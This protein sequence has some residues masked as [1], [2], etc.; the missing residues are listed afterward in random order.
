MKRAKSIPAN[1]SGPIKGNTVYAELFASALVLAGST[2]GLA[3]TGHNFLDLFGEKFLGIRKLEF[4]APLEKGLRFSATTRN[5][6]INVRG[7]EG[8]ECRATAT[9]KS[10]AGSE[11]Q[12]KRLADDTKVT[13]V[14]S[15]AGIAVKI[16]TPKTGMG[17]SISVSL[18]VQVPAETAIDLESRNGAL[19]VSEI[20]ADV[21]VETR[22]GAVKCTSISG[23]VQAETR[24]GSIKL[25]RISCDVKAGTRNGKVT[26]NEVTGNAHIVT[27]NGPIITTAVTGK[28]DL[29]TS[30]GYIKCTQ[31]LGDVKART[32]NGRI[33]VAYSN[34][35]PPV[36]EVYL[37]TSNGSISLD[38]PDDVS[39]AFEA[40]T[41][42]G[43]IKSNLPLVIERS[44]GRHLRGKLGDGEGNILLETSNSSITVK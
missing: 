26:A 8:A 6:Y 30:N 36:L 33:S 10:R 20:E 17:E 22:N 3:G 38:L 11:R 29:E 40:N 15:E 5:G 21:E 25:T 18:D 34:D 35:A 44:S 19:Q 42:N 7:Y 2:F 4:V 31:A 32:T 1:A 39:A 27:R 43:S 23:R 28:L 13:L 37:K 14:K 41:A 12:A 24:N 16:E 9:I